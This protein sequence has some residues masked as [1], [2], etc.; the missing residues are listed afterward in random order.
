MSRK[1]ITLSTLANY[2]KNKEKFTCLTVYDASFAQILDQSGIDVLLVGDSLGMVIQGH[3]TTIPV[4]MQDMLYHTRIVTRNTQYGFVLADM[5]FMSFAT[6]AEAFTNSAQLL[7][8]GAHAIKLE[9]ANWLLPTIERLS[10]RGIPVCGHL[11]LLPQSIHLLGGYKVQ[12]RR[13][14]QAEALLRQAKNLQNAGAQLLVLECIP[15]ALAAEITAAV[16]IPVIGIGAG[17]D[18]DAQVLVLYDM[19]GITPGYSPK[20]TRVFL[21]NQHSTIPDAIKS[22]VEAVKSGSFPAQEHC[23]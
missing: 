12:G 21:D 2:K 5:P 7:Q 15:A 9:G 1:K 23:F 17:P 8:A 18:T 4:S 11:G 22:Y 16:T 10:E 13:I 20:F 3:D 14:E 19:L 6:E